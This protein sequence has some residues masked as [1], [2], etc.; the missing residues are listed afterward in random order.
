MRRPRKA[1]EMM[2]PFVILCLCFSLSRLVSFYLSLDLSLSLC[3]CLCESVSLS[4][5]LCLC[6][7]S[8]SFFSCDLYLLCFSCHS[9]GRS[10]RRGQ[11]LTRRLSLLH[12]LCLR[13]RLT[14]LLLSHRETSEKRLT[15]KSI[16][17]KNSA[18]KVRTLA[19][20]TDLR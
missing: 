16:L 9:R 8:G 11:R 20:S 15:I 2:S 5:N 17:R 14:L 10:R 12:S 19:E 7:H 4:L 18:R 3:S 6:A 1:G 13:N